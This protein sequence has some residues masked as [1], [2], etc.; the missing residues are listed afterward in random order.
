MSGP[1]GVTRPPKRRQGV[2]RKFFSDE[3]NKYYGKLAK[4][5]PY[6]SKK[7][8]RI[9]QLNLCYLSSIEWSEE[10]KI[11]SQDWNQYSKVFYQGWDCKNQEMNFADT[12]MLATKAN[13]FDNP[14]W[15]QSMN[16]PDSEGFWEACEE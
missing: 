9:G 13:A 15:N 10:S 16:G 4:I 1:A 5:P 2:R 3:Y 11:P 8:L 6:D 14:T 12:R 7:K